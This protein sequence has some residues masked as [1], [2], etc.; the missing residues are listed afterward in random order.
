MSDN[1]KGSARRGTSKE[2]RKR[3]E[4]NYDAIF[5][6]PRNI[7]NVTEIPKVIEACTECPKNSE[8]VR[9]TQFAG[10]H[11]YCDLHAKLEKDFGNEDNYFFWQTYNDFLKSRK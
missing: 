9:R 5:R 1:G 2:E 4:D 8:W 6:K 11:F 10:D 7:K 3:F